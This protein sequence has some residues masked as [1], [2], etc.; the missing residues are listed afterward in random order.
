MSP[1]EPAKKVFTLALFQSHQARSNTEN[2]TVEATDLADATAQAAALATEKGLTENFDWEINEVAPPAP[3]NA[4]QATG[5]ATDNDADD[6]QTVAQTDPVAGGTVA[7]A[8]STP[9]TPQAPAATTSTGDLGTPAAP[10]TPAP[11]A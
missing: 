10:S 8:P 9:A 6:A 2:F 11:T 4:E 5:Q 3:A 7:S 1:N